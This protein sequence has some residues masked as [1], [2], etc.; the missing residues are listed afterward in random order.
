MPS[1]WADFT[2]TVL[3]SSGAAAYAQAQIAFPF[4][5][6]YVLQILEQVVTYKLA[7]AV[8]LASRWL[9]SSPNS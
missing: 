2:E 3:P 7:E 9:Q 8:A 1:G 6:L 5:A 4:G